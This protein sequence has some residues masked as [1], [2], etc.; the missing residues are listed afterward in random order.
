MTRISTAG[1]KGRHTIG[2]RYGAP[3]WE[4]DTIQYVGNTVDPPP[5]LA[6]S[7]T[8]VYVPRPLRPGDVQNSCDYNH[9]WSNHVNGANFMFA[10]GSVRFLPILGSP[11]Y[12]HSRRGMAA[13]WW[14]RGTN[15]DPTG[16]A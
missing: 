12:R 16:G 15:P 3:A 8:C 7:R 1:G 10:D 5:Q 4:F 9:Y 14:T 2:W 13:K 6:P 11:S